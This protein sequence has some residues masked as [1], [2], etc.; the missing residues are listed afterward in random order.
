[1]LKRTNK[2]NKT[3]YTYT[4]EFLFPGKEF[5]IVIENK[6]SKDLPYNKIIYYN[7]VEDGKKVQYKKSWYGAGD[8]MV[9]RYRIVKGFVNDHGKTFI[10]RNYKS[11]IGAYRELDIKNY[12]NGLFHGE[13]ISCVYR[14][15]GTI[16]Q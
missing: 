6:N 11:D 13:Q 12:K 10:I 3:E 14:V 1:M 9:Y 15:D 7:T 4:N 2:K 5:I 16:L 8:I